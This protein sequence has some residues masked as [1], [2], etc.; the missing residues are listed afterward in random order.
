MKNLIFCASALSFLAS[1]AH[2]IQF[3]NTTNDAMHVL[4]TVGEY[5]NK[6][7][8]VIPAKKMISIDLT[9]E[10]NK[11]KEKNISNPFLIVHAY[12]KKNKAGCDLHYLLSD[13]TDKIDEKII[14]LTL[15]EDE[16]CL[17]N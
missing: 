12:S 16:K 14:S 5:R 1:P 2:S 11:E 8:P 17:I 15:G 10:I 9:K 13:S 6:K 3:K 7:L 4:L